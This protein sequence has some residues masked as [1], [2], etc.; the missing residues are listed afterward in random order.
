M[1]VEDISKNDQKLAGNGF[2]GFD[3]FLREGIPAI[4]PEKDCVPA[5]MSAATRNAAGFFL[6][7]RNELA[8]RAVRRCRET[9]SSSVQARYASI[10]SAFNRL[11]AGR[12]PFSVTLDSAREVAPADALEFL[13]AFDRQDGRQLLQQIQARNCSDDATVFLRRID[14]LYPVLSTGR[15]LAVPALAFDVVPRFRI[16]PE[17]E[18]GANQIVEWQM[19]IGRQTF[20]DSDPEGAK[21]ARWNSGDPVRLMLRFAKDSPDRPLAAAAARVDNRTVSFDFQGAWAL[22]GL[23]RAAHPEP[24]DLAGVRDLEPNILKIDIPVE[25]DPGQPPL[26][27]PEPPTAHFRIFVRL[28]VSQ[29]GKPEPLAASDFPAAAPAQLTCT[30][31]ASE[32]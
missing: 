13:R 1:I 22:F 2:S 29:P 6:S 17:G 26:A 20:R 10:A 4:V 21:P 23:M 25:R 8:D 14:T 12:F 32:F 7:L 27:R 16:N 24:L 5:G 15:E 18:I 3:Q 28:R 30:A 11:L 31:R 9:A 19:D